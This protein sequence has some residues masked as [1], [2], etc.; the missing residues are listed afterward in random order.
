M[1]RLRLK[2]SHRLRI[3][4]LGKF[5]TGFR[6]MSRLKIPALRIMVRGL[7][8]IRLRSPALRS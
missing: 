2:L 5:L 3:C 8:E 7:V 1:L 6:L 4:V